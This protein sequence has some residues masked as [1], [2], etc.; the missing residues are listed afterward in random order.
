MNVYSN[1]SHSALKYLKNTEV[2]IWNLLIITDDFNIHDSLWDSSYPH[3]SSISDNLLIIANLFNLDLSFPTNYILT[4]Y[5][6]NKNNSNSV[7]DLM[8]LRSGSSKLDNHIIHLEW[9]LSS[10]HASFIIIIPIFEEHIISSK[11]SISKGS[12]EEEAFIKNVS[13]VYKN[14][15]M[16]NILDSLSLDN[17]VNDLTQKIKRAWDKHLKMVKITKH[18]KSWWNNKCSHGLETYRTTKSLNDW[19]AFRRTV[20]FTKRTF[21]DLKIQ[22]IANKKQGL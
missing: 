9:H 18:S 16:S 17:L 7:I 19:K 1:L 8:F 11:C 6:D 20:K 15:N 3:H 14:L 2:N 13:W 10:D 5:S 12:E 21:F 22:K 4:R